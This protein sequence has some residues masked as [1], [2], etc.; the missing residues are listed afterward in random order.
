MHA[1]G[2]VLILV[3]IRYKKRKTLYNNGFSEEISLV[4]TYIHRNIL[5]QKYKKM[6][7]QTHTYCTQNNTIY[8]NM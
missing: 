3:Q 5:I 6:E 1:I 7:R 2:K 4:V 8:N